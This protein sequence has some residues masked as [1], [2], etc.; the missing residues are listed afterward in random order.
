MNVLVLG[1]GGREHALCWRL[2]QDDSVEKIAAAPGNPGIVEDG[3]ECFDID[4]NDPAQVC[5]TVEN[6]FDLV[7]VGPEAPLVA[8]VADA[9]RE[10]GVSVFGPSKDGAQLEGSKSWMK[11][12]LVQAGVPTAQHKTFQ[13][14]ELES[15]LQFL[16]DIR[17]TS[18]VELS[19]IKTD[20]LAGG[21]GVTVT[22]S[23]EEAREAVKQYLSGDAFGDA[24][25]TCVIEEG[26]TGPEISVFA[27]CDG[28]EATCIGVAQDHK[29][30]YDEDR[31]P[32]TGGMGAYSPVPFVDDLM[33][34]EVMDTCISPTL[35][36]LQERGISYRGVLYAGLMLTP[37]GPKMIEYNIRFGDPECQI[38]MMRLTGDLAV[39][40]KACADGELTE[41]LMH[42]GRFEQLGLSDYNAITVVISANGY[43]QSPVLGDVI[44]GIEEANN[45][46]GVK[47]FHAGTK[48]VDG[49]LV[50]SGGRV[51][52]VTAIA[53]DLKTARD[54][55]YEACELI[56]LEGSH[57]RKDI[58]YQ[59]TEFEN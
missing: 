5:K 46:E 57:Y 56:S 37:T 40:L 7:V 34:R 8:G 9:L 1:S 32:N 33:I 43:P 30:I 12:L 54:R 20:G 23:L 17:K 41:V 15:A 21:K 24:G 50:S 55:A 25:K 4:P 59:A 22:E 29:R 47:V 44:S 26:L 42:E 49:K 48:L 53:A 52:N 18:G 58:A 38:L 2:S 10:I 13:P 6:K 19:I 39:A 28:K 35:K 3:F 51:L 45:I 11:D 31:G 36:E 16:E 14:D 27:I